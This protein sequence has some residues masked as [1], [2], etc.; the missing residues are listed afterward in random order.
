M[1][2]DGVFRTFEENTPPLSTAAQSKLAAAE[3]DLY[4]HAVHHHASIICSYNQYKP[5]LPYH[6]N[7]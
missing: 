7:W 6:A 3:N 1:E 2:P 5:N 4:S